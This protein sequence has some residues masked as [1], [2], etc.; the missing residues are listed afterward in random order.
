MTMSEQDR[1]SNQ[2]HAYPAGTTAVR[3]SLHFQSPIQVE[4]AGLSHPG[5][6]RSKNE[7][8][9]YIARFGR[10][11]ETLHTNVSSGEGLTRSEESNYGILVA[12]GIGGGSS[13]EVASQE[14]IH[15]LLSLVLQAPDWILRP[16]D[17][18][19][20]E[21]ILRRAATRISQINQALGQHAQENS[22]LHGFGTT[23]TA[24]WNL[25]MHLFVTHVG[26]S[27]AYLARGGKMEQLTH[28]HTFA[29][30]MVD[31]GMIASVEASPLRLRHVLTRA[32]GDTGVEGTPQLCQIDLKDG[33]TLLVCTDGLTDMVPD[34]QIGPTLTGAETCEA[35]CR[36]LLE[37][38]LR[39]GG[40]DNITIA[41]ARYRTTERQPPTDQTN[42]R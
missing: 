31:R 38:A 10:F 24:A 28:D 19:A 37:N 4:V 22:A 23:F 18:T 42:N 9:Y 32:L 34:D 35:A 15:V 1:D 36:Q 17:E 11:L 26:D 30:D 5:N 29:Q 25:G 41:V 33:D 6:V 2:T 14:A 21:Q 3:S 7:D 12:D 8:H 20:T 39:A 27:R 40:K 13:G 16:Q